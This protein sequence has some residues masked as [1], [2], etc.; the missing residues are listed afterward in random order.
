M[1][2]GNVSP[3]TTGITSRWITGLE[4]GAKTAKLLGENVGDRHDVGVGRDF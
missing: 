1:G 2:G 3:H 4:T